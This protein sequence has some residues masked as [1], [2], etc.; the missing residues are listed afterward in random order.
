MKLFGTVVA[1]S[2]DKLK[3]ILLNKEIYY[4][5]L[6]NSMFPNEY[7]MS[8]GGNI[9]EFGLSPIDV[10]DVEGNLVDSCDSITACS[11][12]YQINQTKLKLIKIAYKPIANLLLLC[13]LN[14]NVRY[15]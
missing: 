14:I 2:K 7:N 13:L 3:I 15:N 12:K 4:I 5:S 10:Y 1:D 9:R 6:H 8:P 11:K